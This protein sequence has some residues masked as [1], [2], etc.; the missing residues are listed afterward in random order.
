[1]AKLTELEL[2]ALGESDHGR[3]I[4]DDGNLRGMVRFSE[5]RKVSVSFTWRYRFDGKK[6]DIRCGTWPT[7]RLS[8][9]R[10]VRD[11]AR[12]ILDGGKDPALERKA[13][14]LEAKAV[15]QIRVIQLQEQLTRPTVRDLY[16]RWVCLELSRRRDG[17]AEVRRG[18]E[19]DVLPNIGLI[20][21]EDVGRAHVTAVLDGILARGANRLANRTLSEMRQMF[22][23]GLV[24]DMVKADPTHRIKKS[25]IGGKEIERD[26]FLSE[27]EIR[28]LAEK[29]PSGHFHR[30]TEC[31][32]WIMLST[33]CRV[34]EISRAQWSDVDPVTRTWTVPA[35][36]AKNQKAHVI[37][38]SDFALRQ[39]NE[40]RS[41]AADDSWIFPAR[42]GETHVCTKSISKQIRDRQ[43]IEPMT[44]RT[45]SAGVLRL[46]G[47]EWTPHDLRRTGATLMGALGVRPDVIDRCLN[48]V[49]QN[50]MV[51]IYQRQKLE[52]EQKEAWRM[53]GERLDLLTRKASTKVAPWSGALKE[54]P[55]NALRQDSDGRLLPLGMAPCDSYAQ[56]TSRSGQTHEMAQS[57]VKASDDFRHR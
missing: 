50:R 13:T 33:C 25:D 9:I 38:L 5:T 52:V 17:G 19:K 10:K 47:G 57:Q 46:S 42:R 22:G 31:A 32:I 18:F 55:N 6:K 44:N 30:S 23:F 8:A 29:M 3:T 2:Q 14:R 12:H 54:P 27:D 36:H 21:A 37:Y 51:R 35:E 41:F 53:L 4:Y 45:Q 7:D 39:F 20:P 11:A 49:E 48:H 28:E 24:R 15:Q 40:M 34:G 43:R 56:R 16:D 1:M 26:R